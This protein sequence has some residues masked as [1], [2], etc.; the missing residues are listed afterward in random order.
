MEGGNEAEL[1][2]TYGLPMGTWCVSRIQDF[3]FMFTGYIERNVQLSNNV[4]NPTRALFNEDISAWDVSSA[5][6]M[7]GMF[8]NAEAFNQN[9]SAW[10]TSKVTDMFGMFYTSSFNQD[11]SLWNVANVSEMGFMFYKA[12]S[13]NQTLCAWGEKI[14]TNVKVGFMFLETASCPSQADPNLIANSPLGPFCQACN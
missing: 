7:R 13:F 2:A 12:G 9:L 10:S 8:A 5:T 14:T 4:I 6:T 11:L 3:S 1:S